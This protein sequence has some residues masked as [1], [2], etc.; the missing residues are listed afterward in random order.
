[1]SESKIIGKP[2]DRVDGRLKV[3]GTATYSAEWPLENI[4]YGV[5]IQ[6]TIPTGTIKAI[7]SRAAMK[8]PG[9][10]AVFSFDNQP[11]VLAGGKGKEGEHLF[12]MQDNV[13]R[14]AGQNIA[15]VVGESLETARYA[16]SLVKITYESQPF[17]TA[18][19]DNVARAKEARGHEKADRG[20]IAAGIADSSVQ[21]SATYSTPT[22][23]H[24][25]LEPFATTAHW[26]GD[27]LT[28]YEST[29]SIFPTQ[30]FVAEHL[31]MPPD[32]VRVICKYTGGGFGSKLSVWSHA[33]LAAMAARKLDRPVKVVLDRHQMYGPVGFRP[34]TIQR[35]VLAAKKDGELTAIKHESINETSRFKEFVEGCCAVS[36][37]M[38]RCPNVQTSQLLVATDIGQPTWMRAPGHTPGS[39]ALE[40]AMDE[41]A[42]ALKMD[43]IELRLRNFAD[44]NYES[45]RPWSSNSLR[46]CYRQGA[47]RFGWSNRQQEPGRQKDG[48]ILI[49]WGMAC[50][51]HSVWRNAASVRI[52]LSSDGEALVQSGSQD[53]GTGTYT[54][55]TQIAAERL[56]LPCERVRFELG[57]SNLPD[58]PMSGGSTT[59]GSLG[60]AVALAA[61]GV[62]AKLVDLASNDPAS[63]LHGANKSDVLAENGMLYLKNRPQSKERFADIV[64]RTGKNSLEVKLAAKPGDE[65]SNY[66]MS[67]FG[68]QFA[69]V[70]VDPDL[71]TVRVSRFVGAYGAG[72]ILNP[73]TA[74]SQML[75]GITFGIGMALMEQTYVDD[76]LG[77][78][79][80]ADL[81]EY[82]IPVHGDCGSI[83]PFFVD[84][85]DPH[86]NVL[87]AK[88]IGELG[89]T[90][91][92]AA[93][94][95]A[96]FHATGLRVRDLPITIDK[97]LIAKGS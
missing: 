61:D 30:S 86:V 44:R 37:I 95:N 88:G 79:I 46:E 89:T 36:R 77:R 7:D 76:R 2:I 26:N 52:V 83:E 18:F 19:H 63:P 42:Y 82:H 8:L 43:P 53:I 23:S 49:G 74:R 11:M 20:D 27:S 64:E 39:F 32:K 31:G 73:K 6:S 75:G 92:S 50:A 54:I 96:V 51:Q 55:M 90:G 24:N 60:N 94:A 1:M 14:Y 29:Q 35:I 65:Q 5:L 33:M 16:A 97:L 22:Q 10:I 3:T 81:A 80:N 15:L 56:T 12:L 72:R 38:Y 4:A 57:D 93:I 34:A 62:I 66:S 84:E 85:I 59:A 91:A 47:E 71:Y 17:S 69:E 21:V 13:V 9:A 58:S 48:R 41:L 67:T 87:G 28:L 68:A 45:D 70:R 78:I 40:C 25:P